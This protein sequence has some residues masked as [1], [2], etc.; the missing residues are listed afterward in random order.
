MNIEIEYRCTG[1]SFSARHLATMRAAPS[2]RAEGE[3]K[4]A[5]D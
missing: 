1:V 2:L 4:A 3:R 5:F